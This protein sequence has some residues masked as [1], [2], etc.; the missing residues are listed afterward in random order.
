MVVGFRTIKDGGIPV[1]L[2]EKCI[3]KVP[4]KFGGKNG[5]SCFGLVCHKKEQRR[6]LAERA[7]VGK[8]A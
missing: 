8:V 2:V 1:M 7:A 3:T 5:H 4:R 6:Q